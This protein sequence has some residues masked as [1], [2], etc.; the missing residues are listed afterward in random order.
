MRIKAV[1]Y[2]LG[3]TLFEAHY[4]RKW[5]Y[6]EILKLGKFKGSFSDFYD[7]YESFLLPVYENKIGYETGFDHFLE[8]LK[9]PNA[10]KFKQE[11]FA[12]KKYF[13]ANRVLFPMVKE[14]L[15]ILFD[16]GI[17]NIIVTDNELS[18]NEIEDTVI[19]RFGINPYL[20]KIISSKSF[21]M[22]KSNPELFVK[23][24]GLFQL[25][26]EEVLFVGH[27]KDEIEGASNLG[28]KTVLFNNY[29]NKEVSSSFTIRSFNDIL[30]IIE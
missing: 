3:D 5:N 24:L 4:W 27:D 13:E 16:R 2:D 9:I 15:A 6:D 22:T 1:L 30:G 7:L 19:G 21:G 11:S 28:I 8:F 18:E 17:K 10:E 23:V 26:T 14:T 29:L 25:K 20:D 12:K